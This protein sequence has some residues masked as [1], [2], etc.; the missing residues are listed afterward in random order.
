VIEAAEVK[1]TGEV[2]EFRLL[3]ADRPAYNGCIEEDERFVVTF[4]NID[5]AEAAEP[6][7]GKNPLIRSCEVVRLEKKVRY[8]FTLYDPRNFYGFDLHYEDGA[9]V[10]TLK[11]PVKLDLTAEKPLSGI[12]IVLDAGHGGWDP[13]A[14]GAYVSGNTR[15]SEKD[16]NFSVMLETA[17]LLDALGAEIELLREADVTLPLADRMAYLEQSEPDLCISVHQNSVGYTT[18]ATR[19]RGTL[20][21]WCMDSGRLLSDCVGASVADALSRSF[22]GSDYQALA[23]CRNPKFPQT[24]IE[25]GFMTSVEEYEK[26]VHG[27]GIR[28]AAEGIRSGV[29]EYFRKQAEFLGE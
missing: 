24:L 28:K 3:C 12:R 22:R 6:E 13:G 11:N 29:L 18:D 5:A 9:V 15:I 8:A 10:V 1:D 27:D 20:S 7:I 26:M 16:L 25:V 2:T 4:Y 21:L 19:V 14:L 23:M 17:F